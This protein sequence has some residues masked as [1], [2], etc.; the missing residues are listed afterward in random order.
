MLI[1]LA[2]GRSVGI[3]RQ[4]PT[5]PSSNFRFRIRSM[6][7][8]HYSRKPIVTLILT[9]SDQATRRAIRTLGNPWEHRTTFVATEG[10]LLAGDSESLV[11]QQCG[12]G[13]DVN[14]PTKIEPEVNLRAIIA[15]TDRLVGASRTDQTE[16][17]I[18]DPDALYSCDV[19]IDMPEPMSQLKKSLTIQL[20]GAEKE[21][22][23]L[24]AAW[25]LSTREQIAGLMGGVTTHRAGQIIRSLTQH[26]LVST[27]G[28]HHY[29]T[30]KGFTYLARRDRAAVG[31]LLDRW[32][33]ETGYQPSSLGDHPDL[34]YPGTTL[35][36]I[37]SQLEHHNGIT[38]F[39][40]AL[41]AGG[42]PLPGLRGVG[43]V[44]H[45]PVHH[46]VLVLV[47]KLRA[48]SRTHRFTL[49][50]QR[51]MDSLL[52]G[53]REK[54]HDAEANPRPLGVLPTVL[55]RVVGQKGTT[56]GNC[57]WCCSFSRP[58]TKRQPS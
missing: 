46:W 57:P 24:L 12:E 43:P 14:P 52:A 11:W 13:R 16:K 45:V 2:G 30:D 38:D 35:R 21:A 47:D 15:W 50:L 3:M 6:E 8:L 49:D 17:Q 31:P 33:A 58:G 19:R 44:A 22:L 20:I 32:T 7:Q 56:V 25:P 23:D 28:A 53:V 5:L 37:I 55:P 54:G 10:E 27:R 41:M 42:S 29:L 9:F 26:H 34:V 18:P 40:A 36:T 1:T 39:A 48:A 4:G 51:Q